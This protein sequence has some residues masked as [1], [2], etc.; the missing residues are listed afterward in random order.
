M[1]DRKQKAEQTLV[2]VIIPAY[3][4]EQYIGKTLK[5]VLG[6][7]HQNLQVIV[8]DDGST[9][10]TFKVCEKIMRFD[11]RLE[12]WSIPHAGVSAARNE[13][14]RHAKGE[15]TG[16]VDGDD[17][18]VPKMYEML[19]DQ[20][21]SCDADA[22]EASYFDIFE[23]GTA[24]RIRRDQQV[25]VLEGRKILEE[26]LI[27]GHH[28]G[29]ANFRLCRQSIV[30]RCHFTEGMANYEDVYFSLQC[31][32]KCKRTCYQEVSLYGYRKRRG[33][34]SGWE[35]YRD[36]GMRR[37]NDARMIWKAARKRHPQLAYAADTFHFNLILTEARKIYA[38]KQIIQ[39]ETAVK[40]EM[41]S[42]L[43]MV[44]PAAKKYVSTGRRLEYLLL[45][46]TKYGAY[47]LWKIVNAVRCLKKR[48]G[49]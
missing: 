4:L 41:L 12:L 5:S 9:D 7:T 44:Y 32:E 18:L 36:C 37:V 2:S 40:N 45:V 13:G 21:L 29:S 47:D 14:I 16:F 39:R 25:H 46:H 42:D 30:K 27:Y 10:G 1:T 24:G 22:A 48:Q 17:F 33:S 31:L 3:N 34:A 19:L 43:K 6:Q 26:F 38:D 23:N 35:G 49:G 28:N 11:T 8:I 20:I 15:F